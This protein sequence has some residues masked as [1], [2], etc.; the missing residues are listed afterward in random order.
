MF[1]NFMTWNYFKPLLFAPLLLALLSSFEYRVIICI[2]Y[3][4]ILAEFK[5][6]F[7]VS[8]LLPDQRLKKSVEKIGKK[9]EYLSCSERYPVN[10][11]AYI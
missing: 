7:A 6:D 8:A 10:I 1:F 5:A 4:K 9:K 11:R 3:R 2:V